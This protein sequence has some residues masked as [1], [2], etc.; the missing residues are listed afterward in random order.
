VAKKKQGLQKLQRQQASLNE[1][2]ERMM[3]P[4]RLAIFKLREQ[5]AE[6]CLKQP[7]ERRRFQNH[8]LIK[9]FGAEFESS[10]EPKKSALMS[11]WLL[12]G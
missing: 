2:L 8:R 10:R 11:Y 4:W 3:E 1:E 12:R 7:P 5:L 9:N 6:H